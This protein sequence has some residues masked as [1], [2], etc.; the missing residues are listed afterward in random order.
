MKNLLILF[1]ISSGKLIA[2]EFFVKKE[3]II[4]DTK[5]N[6]RWLSAKTNCSTKKIK[7]F[8]KKIRYF[9]GLIPMQALNSSFAKDNIKIISNHSSINISKVSNL[10]KKN[11]DPSLIKII[12]FDK[13]FESL[14][15]DSY[16]L[17]SHKDIAN[18]RIS[19]KSSLYQFLL[20]KKENVIYTTKNITPFEG[21]NVVSSTEERAKWV[22]PVDK[23]EHF[24][25]KTELKKFLKHHSLKSF[26]KKNTP[27]KK[28]DFRK[29]SLLSFGQPVKVIF[30]K[31]NLI[32]TT[33]GVP[34]S[35][36]GIDDPVTIRLKN[37]EIISARVIDVGVVSASL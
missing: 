28:S 31:K 14:T 15:T 13:H 19:Q 9:D 32:I 7:I 36:G 29:K 3:I 12:K 34:Q 37:K 2:C 21:G 18:L 6:D 16:S 26:V 4:N 25:S 5:S 27:L 11:F 10:L 8:D 33:T 22:E 35:N 17:T 30:K 23:E 1:L 20:Q 24:L